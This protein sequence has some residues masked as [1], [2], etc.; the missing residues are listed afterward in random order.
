[1][2]MVLIINAISIS[3]GFHGIKEAEGSYQDYLVLSLEF[4]EQC[5]LNCDWDNLWYGGYSYK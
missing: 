4:L 2:V 5:L 3:E 1:M